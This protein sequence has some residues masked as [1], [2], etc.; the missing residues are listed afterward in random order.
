MNP[1]L[2]SFDSKVLEIRDSATYIA[3]LAVDMQPKNSI[4]RWYLRR[5]GF[6]CDGRP[7]V[8]MTRLE[9]CGWATSDP[10]AWGGRTFPAAHNFIIDHWNELSDGDVVDV[11]FI[12]GESLVK[13]VSERMTIHS[14]EAADAQSPIL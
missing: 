9:A 2:S 14:M 6:P 8:L 11:E 10:Y 12:L 3:V 7:N 1:C 5:E 4:Q 13:K